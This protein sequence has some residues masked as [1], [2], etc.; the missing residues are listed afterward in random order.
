VQ[1]ASVKASRV[2]VVVETAREGDGNRRLKAGQR[3]VALLLSAAWRVEVTAAARNS[4]TPL[5][6]V[7]GFRFA[8]GR[9]WQGQARTDCWREL[10]TSDNRGEW[11][12][13]VPKEHICRPALG[14][15]AGG[16]SE[17]RGIPDCYGA[18]G[19]NLEEGSQP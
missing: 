2:S 8:K 6:R 5:A 3:C 11:L 10:E 15:F 12:L 7:A 18:Q 17:G 14:F 9:R 1:V 13:P 19:R 4:E 16:G